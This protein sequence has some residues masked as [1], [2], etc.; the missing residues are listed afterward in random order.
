MNAPMLPPEEVARRRKAV[1][2]T[3]WVAGGIAL[4]IFV[5]FILRG[6]LAA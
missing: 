4:A 5:A 3:V 2:R 1:L 6:V